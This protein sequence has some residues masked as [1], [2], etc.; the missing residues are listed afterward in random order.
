M[1]TLKEFF[2]RYIENTVEKA[3]VAEKRIFLCLLTVAVCKG[4][5]LESRNVYITARMLKHL[6]DKKPAEECM[7]ILNHVYEM[8]RYPDKVYQNKDGKR[9]GFVFVKRMSAVDYLVAIEDIITNEVKE[10][11]IATAFR[12]RDEKYIKNYTLLWDWGNGTPHRSAL[13]APGKG[14]Y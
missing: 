5:G 8:V 3:V 9:G 11:Q 13:D 2:H 4:V 6:Y 12:L 7:F 1:K 14:V 10:I